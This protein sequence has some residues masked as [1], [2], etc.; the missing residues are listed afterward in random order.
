MKNIVLLGGGGLALEIYDYM[1][2]EG[3]CPLGYCSPDKGNNLNGVLDWL[4]NENDVHDKSFEYVIASG[5]I[6]IR[7]LMIDFLLKNNSNIYSFISQKSYVSKFAKIGVGAVVLP[8]STITGNPVIGNY[9]LVNNFASIHHDVQIGDNAVL[10][11]GARI[12]GNCKVG[13]NFFMGLNSCLAPETTVGDNVDISI[14][15]YMGKKVPSDVV[16]VSKSGVF[17]KK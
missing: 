8:F 2:N 3:I 7:R 6:S 13:E 5:Y 16:V 15:T 9:V 17:L 10:S 12:P 14:N 1:R 11:P 4:G